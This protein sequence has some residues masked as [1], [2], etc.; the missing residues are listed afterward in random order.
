MKYEFIKMHA[1][2]YPVSSLCKHLKVSKSGYYAHCKHEPSERQQASDDL[3]TSIQE[4]YEQSG[5]IYGSPRI[6]VELLNRGKHCSLGRVKRLMRQEGIYRIL[7]SKSRV[8][9]P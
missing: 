8:F 9:D 3:I 7:S 5:Q 4:I 6:H 2:D 1:E